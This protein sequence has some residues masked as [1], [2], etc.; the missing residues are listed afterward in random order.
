MIGEDAS[1]VFYGSPLFPV[2]HF[3]Q[4][5]IFLRSKA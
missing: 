1:N 3:C 4:I 5:F 2:L